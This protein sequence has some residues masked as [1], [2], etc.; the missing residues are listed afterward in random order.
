MKILNVLL[1][2]IVFA[3][4]FA[5]LAS[6]LNIHEFAFQMPID[7][8]FLVLQTTVWALFRELELFANADRAVKLVTL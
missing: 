1:S 7:W 5:L 4:F 2:L 3:Q 6:K 8:A